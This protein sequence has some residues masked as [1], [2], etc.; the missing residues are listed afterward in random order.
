MIVNSKTQRSNEK[1]THRDTRNK[2]LPIL[3][4]EPLLEPH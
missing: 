2:Q 3:N 1:V 4:P